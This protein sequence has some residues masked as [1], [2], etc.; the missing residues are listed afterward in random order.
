[1]L[2]SFCALSI[3]YIRSSNYM[4]FE[5]PHQTGLIVQYAITQCVS[6]S[7]WLFLNLNSNWRVFHGFMISVRTLGERQ[8]TST[9]RSHIHPHSSTAFHKLHLFSLPHVW[10]RKFF[11]RH[12]PPLN[13]PS[14]LR[15]MLWT[16]QPFKMLLNYKKK[17]KGSE[18]ILMCRLIHEWLLL[19]ISY[20]F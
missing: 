8:D 12:R 17:K 4:F 20:L 15:I 5:R 1:M 18:C 3:K 7:F 9:L 14:P 2:S 10:D 19:V 13:T 11:W 16:Q 6:E